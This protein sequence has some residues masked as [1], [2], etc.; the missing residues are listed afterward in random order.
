[1]SSMSIQDKFTPFVN[2]LKIWS[3]YTIDSV[4]K[5]SMGMIIRYFTI[6]GGIILYA[7]N[8]NTIS[9]IHKVIDSAR[10]AHMRA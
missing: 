2:V 3:Y 7:V 4:C 6:I 8:D 5:W 10:E 9:L 1:M